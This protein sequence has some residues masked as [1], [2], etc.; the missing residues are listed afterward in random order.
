[1]PAIV[2]LIAELLGLV[3]QMAQAGIAIAGIVQKARDVLDAN[4]A[5]GDPDWD[6]LDGQIKGLQEQLAQDPPAP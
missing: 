4:A 5:P 3:P 6:A 1:M 2:A